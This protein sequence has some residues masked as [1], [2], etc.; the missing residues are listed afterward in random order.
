M[1]SARNGNG[2][3]TQAIRLT[4][5]A[6]PEYITL[7]RLALTGIARLRPEP[8]SPEV[9]GDLKLALTEACT[10]SVRHAYGTATGLVEIVY[11][12]HSDRLVVEV[13]RPRRRVRAA[14][15][16]RRRRGVRASWR[17]A[18]SGSPSS[19]RSPTSSRSAWA[20]AAA[21]APV[22]EAPQ[23]SAEMAG[24]R[25]LIVVSN[26]GP[27]TYD[28]DAD[29]RAHRAPRRRRARD[30]AAR[31]A[32][33]PRRHVDRERDDR[34]GSRRRRGGGRATVVSRRARPGRVRR[35]LQRR[36][37]PDAVV[38]PALA[39][40]PAASRPDLDRAFHDAWRDGYGAVNRAF[41]DAVVAELDDNPDATVFFH[42]YHL[43]LA[44]AL[45]REARPDALLAHFVHIPW[46]R[47]LDGPA[48]APCGARCT[49]ACSRT[50]SSRFHTDALG[51]QLRAQ[52][53]RRS[54]AATG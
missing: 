10:N 50:T 16:T 33:P 19:R 51:A 23:C 27:V 7:G 31:A 48:R 8:F 20:T 1:D 9:L 38:H 52:L 43:Y 6:K 42:D 17:R 39:V 4:I 2:N 22:R 34:R 44:P 5:P 41:A 35:L 25:S 11:E 47:R 45:V 13:V 32:R 15:R 28:R 3:G 12:L 49:T 26:R 18:A 40:G 53:R 29:G 24:R 21:R 36:R 54:P 46:P 14:E 30:R 37:E